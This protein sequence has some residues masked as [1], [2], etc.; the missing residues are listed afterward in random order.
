MNGTRVWEQWE[1][2]WR[3]DRPSAAELEAMIA[4]TRRARRGLTLVRLLSGALAVAALAVVAAALR[5]AGN[6]LEIALGIVV[7]IGIVAVWSLDSLNH[8][9]AVEHVEA[10][11]DEYRAA[12]RA[13]CLRQERFAKLGWIVVA[14]DLT[15]LIPWW[16]GGIAVHGAGFHAAQILTIWGPLA[17][18][19]GFVAWTIVLR[20]R[21][22]TELR[23]LAVPT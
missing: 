9:R 18:M 11:A 17:M 20:R 16:I 2:S 1:E 4:R 14:L 23:R 21:A 22:R 5:H 10:P 12:R 7:S 15:F 3:A 8:R 19:A 6:A 13:L